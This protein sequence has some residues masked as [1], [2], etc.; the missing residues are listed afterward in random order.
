VESTRSAAS[1]R[2]TSSTASSSGA[3]LLAA[4]A[5]R[6]ASMRSPFFGWKKRLFS[7]NV[8]VK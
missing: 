4:M 3:R 8:S 5:S 7:Q 1:M 2:E 6:I